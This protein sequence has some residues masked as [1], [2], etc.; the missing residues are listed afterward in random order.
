MDGTQYKL[1]RI[2]TFYKEIEPFFKEL[3]EL[4]FEVRSVCEIDIVTEASEMTKE[5]MKELDI[6]E[7]IIYDTPGLVK[8]KTLDNT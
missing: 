1:S 3:E 4:G 7:V 6:K 8:D 2:S 5:I